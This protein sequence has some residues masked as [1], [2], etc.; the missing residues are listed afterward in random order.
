MIKALLSSKTSVLTRGMWHNIPENGIPPLPASF[1][2]CQ[3]QASKE[4]LNIPSTITLFIIQM[5]TGE[6]FWNLSAE[7]MQL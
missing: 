2:R 6:N 1:S 4:L 7:Y 5:A 3:I